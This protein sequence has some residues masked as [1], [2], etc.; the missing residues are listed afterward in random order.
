MAPYGAVLLR[1]ESTASSRIEHLTASALAIATTEAGEGQHGSNAAEIVARAFYFDQFHRRRNHLDG[2]P[3]FIERTERIPRAVY[4]QHRRI[5]FREV[6]C[7]QLRWFAGRVQRIGEQQQAIR[8]AGRFGCQHTRLPAAIRLSSEPH[9][10][11]MMLFAD[12]QNLFTQAFPVARRVPRTRWSFGALLSKCQI[13][14][15][16]IHSMLDERV[17]ESHKQRSVAV[18]SSAVRE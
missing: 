14:T 16:H 6:R 9:L 4:E 10:I 1:S 2:G 5:Q 17:C 12:L 18:G 8:E 11:G 7:T 15:Q 13:V 3:H